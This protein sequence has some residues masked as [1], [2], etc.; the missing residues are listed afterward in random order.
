M[1]PSFKNKYLYKRRLIG[2]GKQVPLK[3]AHFLELDLICV[4]SNQ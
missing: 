4:K 3:C 1:I 2:L